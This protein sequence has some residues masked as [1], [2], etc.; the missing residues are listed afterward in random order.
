MRLLTKAIVTTLLSLSSVCSSAFKRCATPPFIRA[1]FSN[2]RCMLVLMPAA[3][4]YCAHVSPF[5]IAY[6][7]LVGTHLLTPPLSANFSR[8][9]SSPHFPLLLTHPWSNDKIPCV[10]GACCTPH[11][12]RYFDNHISVS[13]LSPPPPSAALI[14]TCTITNLSQR[15]QLPLQVVHSN[16]II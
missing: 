1:R 2:V 9:I 12:P 4:Q 6:D 14:H 7:V 11:P 8:I 5:A 15:A 10:S 3:A 16:A 13:F